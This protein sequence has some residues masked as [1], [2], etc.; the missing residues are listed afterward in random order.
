MGDIV[1]INIKENNKNVKEFNLL[2]NAVGWGAYDEK[3]LKI[4]LEN[5]FYS[6]SVYD[7]NK[8]IGYG[9]IIGDNICFILVNYLLYLSRFSLPLNNFKN[10]MI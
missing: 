2:Y 7:D 10:Y 8:I 5:T 1:N 9:R 4:A 3:I 6:V